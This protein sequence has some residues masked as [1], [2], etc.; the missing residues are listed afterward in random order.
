[1]TVTWESI[2]GQAQ[3]K[4][5][6]IEAIE[7][8]YLHPELFRHYQ[9]RPPKGILL[10]GPPGC[11]KTL[12]GK[13]TATAIGS[14]NGFMYI[15]APSLLR[16]IVGEAES[17]IR[18]LFRKAREHKRLTDRPAVLFIDE[19]DA[20]LGSRS[21]SEKKRHACHDSF[22]ASFLTE[23]DGMDDCGA[24]VI[25]ATNRPDDIDPAIVRDGRIE[26]KIRIGRPDRKDCES[27]LRMNLTPLPVKGS[28]QKGLA[29]IMVRELFSENRVI[30]RLHT[31]QGVHDLRLEHV[32]NGAML[33]G[34]VHQATSL[35]LRRDITAKTQTGISKRDVVNAINSIQQQQFDLDHSDAANEVLETLGAKLRRI[36]KVKTVPT[37]IQEEM[38]SGPPNI[39][40]EVA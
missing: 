15:A 14:P 35:A 8:P 39:F 40:E 34:A 12:L 25:L 6:L 23:M 31:E 16:G 20:V 21:N 7:L 37:L 24:I 13:A 18:D 3:A 17:G 26:R 28:T 29:R 22:V 5:A 33:A 10:Y 32:I 4:A 36:E 27:I 2:G 19:A 1:M 11:G 30:L 38:V 9:K